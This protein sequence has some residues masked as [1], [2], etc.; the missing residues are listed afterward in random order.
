MEV[1]EEDCSLGTRDHQNK[2]DD[3]EEPEH[4]IDLVSPEGWECCV[5]LGRHC[6]CSGFI[7]RRS[8]NSDND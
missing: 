7:F 2:E 3:K 5:S 4:V 6:K 1:T 8:S